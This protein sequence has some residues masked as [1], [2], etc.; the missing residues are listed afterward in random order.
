MLFPFSSIEAETAGKLS[1]VL[2]VLNSLNFNIASAPTLFSINR[3]KF[4]SSKLIVPFVILL[5]ID[6]F[7]VSEF[8]TKVSC[9]IYPFTTLE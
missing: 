5:K 4:A 9:P 7:L 8:I 6:V 2:S 1:S 3:F